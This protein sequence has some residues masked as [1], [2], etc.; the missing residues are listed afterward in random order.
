MF[1]STVASTRRVLKLQ[2][3]F[4]ECICLWPHVWHAPSVMTHGFVSAS[5]IREGRCVY[6]C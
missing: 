5:T 1:V 4:I 3:S 2:Q 6:K